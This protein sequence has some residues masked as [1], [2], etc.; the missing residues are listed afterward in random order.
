[1]SSYQ[2]PSAFTT[3]QNSSVG[4][5]LQIEFSPMKEIVWNA[6]VAWEIEHNINMR[7]FYF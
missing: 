6:E 5:D 7:Q 1:M 4:R 3:E 2:H